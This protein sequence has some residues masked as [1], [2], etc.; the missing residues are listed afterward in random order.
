MI[1]AGAAF[2]FTV[3]RGCRS[4]ERYVAAVLV[5]GRKNTEETRGKTEISAGLWVINTARSRS[6]NLKEVEQK[7]FMFLFNTWSGKR[8]R[9]QERQIGKRRERESV[10]DGKRLPGDFSG[11][12]V[13][14]LPTMQRLSSVHSSAASSSSCR[15][16]TDISRSHFSVLALWFTRRRC[17]RSLKWRF[18]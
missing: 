5:G 14:C 6:F 7:C 8:E 16:W 11:V 1:D 18:S 3:S 13:W 2:E 10:R 12:P 4:R 17:C 9:D 15:G